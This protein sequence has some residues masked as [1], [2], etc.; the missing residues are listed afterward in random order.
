MEN[1]EKFSRIDRLKLNEEHYFQSLLEQAYL[2]GLLSEDEL[3]KIQFDCLAI[4]ARRAEQYN[5][6]DS[7]SIQVEAAQNILTSIMF[8]VGLYLKT[9]DCPDDAIDALRKEKLETLYL[10]GRK[11]IDKM[12]NITKLLQG[13]II[14]DLIDT[15]NI[16]YGSTIADG[17]NGFFKLYRQDFS[18][19][20]IHI[21]A[22]Y[23]TYHEVCGL[24]GIEFIKQYLENIYCENSFCN[25]FTADCIHHLLCG[26]HEDYQNLL[27]NLFEPIFITALGCVIAH[28]DV[29]NLKLS[30]ADID[31]LTRIF[32]GASNE[33][34][35]LILQ[36]ALD[37]LRKLFSL[38]AYTLRYMKKGLP[39]IISVIENAIVLNTMD[40]VFLI[41]KYPENTP[42]LSFSFGDKMDDELY[43]KIIDEIMQSQDT[44]TK[45]KIIKENIYSF[46]DLED[47]LLDANLSAEDVNAVLHELTPTE[48]VALIKKHPMLQEIELYNLR[49]SEVLLCNYL[50]DFLIALPPQQQIWIKKA[51]KAIDLID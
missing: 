10:Y 19:H 4:L 1:I 2:I 22:D 8:T 41:S 29:S 31:Y 37:E 25:H 23:P 36:S 35:E 43:R 47:I 45:I 3:E 20:E 33:K 30:F 26:Y 9:C 27:I 16:F 38:P 15:P 13:R 48:I 12:L 46:A 49:E 24:V 7:S 18:A 5:N 6:G 39:K 34:T 42:V 14:N 32:K 51:A 50:N 17:I 11:Q 40:R 21:T 44:S 28:A